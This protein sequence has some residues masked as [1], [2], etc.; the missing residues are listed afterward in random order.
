MSRT[1]N[2]RASSSSS[3]SSTTA[4]NNSGASSSR[5]HQIV[6]PNDDTPEITQRKKRMREEFEE[7]KTLPSKKGYPLVNFS[8]DSAEPAGDWGPYKRWLATLNACP[9]CHVAYR[10]DQ[11]RMCENQHTVC[12]NCASRLTGNMLYKCT[13]C[14]SHCLDKKNYGLEKLLT[15]IMANEI[16]SCQFLGCAHEGKKTK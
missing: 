4:G 13:L 2:N 14:N 8:E 10:P 7:S 11:I 5:G 15:N 1:G 12:V 16:F 9:V 6:V 3:S